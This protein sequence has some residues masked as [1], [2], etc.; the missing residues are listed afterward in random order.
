MSFHCDCK[1]TTL[2]LDEGL[3]FEPSVLASVGL[4]GKAVFLVVRFL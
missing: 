1:M 4:V 2:G 3:A